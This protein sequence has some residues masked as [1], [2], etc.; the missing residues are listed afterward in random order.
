MS[1]RVSDMTGNISKQILINGECC[2]PK[3]GIAIQS[4]KP[5]LDLLEYHWAR[6]G[7]DDT[8]RVPI[9]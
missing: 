4:H 8:A 2:L 9:T 6:H 5:L 1:A 7:E 3:L